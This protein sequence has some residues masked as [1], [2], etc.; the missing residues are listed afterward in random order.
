[1]QSLELQVQIDEQHQIHLQLP[2]TV[3]AKTAK[4]IVIY[5]DMPEAG[6]ASKRVLGQFR[7]E[8]HMA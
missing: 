5:E 1:M 8:I 3:R 6:K 7:G 4:I 2:D